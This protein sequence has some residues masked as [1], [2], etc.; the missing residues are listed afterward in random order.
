MEPGDTAE[1]ILKSMVAQTRT[2]LSRLEVPEEDWETVLN[3]ASLVEREVNNDEYR[4]KAAR[5]I[6]NRLEDGMTLGIDATLA[7]GLD[8]SGLDLTVSD[9]QSDHPYNTRKH[10]GLPPTPIASPGLAAIKAVLD[11]EPGPWLYW[12]TVNFDTGETL[13]AVTY[14]EHQENEAILDQWLAENPTSSEP[15]SDDEG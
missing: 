7:Y 3:K 8:K 5:A 9:L 13:F 11:P 12:V 14:A 10:L 15:D 4:S 1:D 2:E 6:E